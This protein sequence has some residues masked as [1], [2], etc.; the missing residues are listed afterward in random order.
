MSVQR[1]IYLDQAATSWPK[2]DAAVEAAEAFTRQCGA[3]SGRGAYASARTADQ[4]VTAARHNLAQ[5]VGARDA[6]DVAFCSSGTHALN[7]AIGGLLR[8]GA[9]VLTTAIETQQCAQTAGALAKKTRRTGGCGGLRRRMAT[10]R[11][12]RERGLQHHS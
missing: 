5:L 12:L 4:W 3:T 10:F 2:L 9:S 8:P 1:R 11:S 7:A 6:A